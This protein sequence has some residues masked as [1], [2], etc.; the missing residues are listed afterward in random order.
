MMGSQINL[1]SELGQGA[2][3]WFDI[4]LEKS[5]ELMIEEGKNQKADEDIL[6]GLHFLVIDDNHINQKITAKILE[7]KGI[8]CDVANN[9]YEGIELAKGKQYDLILMDILM[10]GINGYIAT[11]NIREF[12]SK[13]PIVALTAASQDDIATQVYESGFD[14]ILTKPFDPDMLF[15]KISE[16]I[17]NK[18]YRLQA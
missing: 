18:Q 13:T 15:S 5:F 4:E 3:F 12:D 9:G 11:E 17:Y 8:T 10:P 14:D 6:A 16:L 1:D 7:R 2:T